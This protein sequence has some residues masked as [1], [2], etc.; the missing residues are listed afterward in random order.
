MSIKPSQVFLALA[1]AALS[2]LP[3]VQA[4]TAVNGIA[5][6]VNGK[7]ITKSEVRDSVNAQ[8]QMLR[9]KHREDQAAYERDM[10]E[11]RETALDSLIDRELILS[12][13][14]KIGGVIKPQYVEDDINGIIRESFK[15]DRDAFVTELAR[16]GM[17]MKKFRELREKMIIVQ[18]MRGRHTGGQPPATPREVN[19]FYQKNNEKFRDK[20]MLKISTITI[21]KFTGDADAGPTKQKKLAEE[22]RSKVVAGG[23][24]ATMAKTYS[25]DSRAE[26]GGEWDWME[27]KQMK[28]SLA[29]AAFNL[30]NGGVSPV[31][32]DETNYIIIY[33]DA[34]KLGDATPLEKVRP[35]IERVIDQEKG[36]AAMDKWLADLRRKAVIKK[37]DLGTLPPIA[38]PAAAPPSAV[39]N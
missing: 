12:E 10:L 34:K 3:V 32:D 29:D 15:G 2:H 35:D 14:A 13:F 1:L 18:V 6:V 21:P 28:K 19:E 31:I 22:I 20:D 27:R 16:T 4:Q 9:I 5:A 36:K 38:P 8:E 33:L 37:M 26:G 11:L 30:K 17:T 7:V 39:S 25:Q 24:F 23:D